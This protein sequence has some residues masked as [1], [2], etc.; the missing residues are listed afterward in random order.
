MA[1]TRTK[2]P[3]PKAGA[4]KRELPDALA[5][6]AKGLRDT[7]RQ[8]LAAAGFAAIALIQDLRRRITGDYLAI[9]KALAELRQEGMAD[10]LGCA[11]FAEICERHFEMSAEHAER[12]VRLAERFERAVALDLGYE[13]AC[14]L[15]ALA[16]ATPAE[17]APE[18]LLHATLTLPSK[19]TLAVDEATTA[20]LF[21]AA[22]EF[23]QARTDA[24]PGGPDKGGRTTTAAERSAFRALQRD[25]AADARFEGVKL[26]QVARGKT[27]GAV[28]RADVPQA[29]WETF[30]RA[31]AKRKKS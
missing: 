12:L 15:L 19:E 29:L 30:V 22:K 24:N 1:T 18:E 23:R 20:Q 16:D 11:D 31:M 4:A 10:A 3:Q 26:A 8:R 17:E 5:K 7:K 14:A 2:T 6:R 9:G 21:A 13:R 25:V 28:I 27:K